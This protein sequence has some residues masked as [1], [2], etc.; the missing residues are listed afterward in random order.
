MTYDNVLTGVFD[1]PQH[2][3]TFHENSGTTFQVGLILLRASF[4]GDQQASYEFLAFA[5][6]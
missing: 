5:E 2:F 3:L 1:T 6:V 4:I